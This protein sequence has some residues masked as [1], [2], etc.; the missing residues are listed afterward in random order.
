MKKKHVLSHLADMPRCKSNSWLCIKLPF[1]FLNQSRGLASSGK[2]SAG[3]NPVY[4]HSTV[5]CD[6]SLPRSTVANWS[7]TE[8]NAISRHHFLHPN[9]PSKVSWDGCSQLWRLPGSSP[10]QT[11]PRPP[12]HTRTQA[13]MHTHTHTHTQEIENRCLNVKLKWDSRAAPPTLMKMET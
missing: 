10:P 5:L 12:T 2:A 13:R 8:A 11:T 1:F 3:P 6:K 7:Y 9:H 4:P